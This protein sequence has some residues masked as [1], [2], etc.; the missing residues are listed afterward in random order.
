MA[1]LPLY[2]G[3]FGD[4]EALQ[5]TTAFVRTRASPSRST[6]SIRERRT[7]NAVFLSACP[8]GCL[9]FSVSVFLSLRLTLSFVCFYVFLAPPPPHPPTPSSRVKNAYGDF[10]TQFQTFS[11]MLCSSSGETD[12]RFNY[13]RQGQASYKPTRQARLERAAM[14]KSKGAQGLTNLASLLVIY[15]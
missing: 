10:Y 11:G 8:S 12:I 5:K 14:T 2:G 15:L 1:K 7:R 9:C 6:S 13:W 4:L 3:L